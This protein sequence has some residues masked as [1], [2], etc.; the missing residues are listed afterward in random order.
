[1]TNLP[2]TDPRTVH[3]GAEGFVPWAPAAERTITLAAADQL[4]FRAALGEPV[5]LTPALKKPGEI[6]RGGS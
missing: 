1:M 3:P 2:P 6:M 4:A 5:E